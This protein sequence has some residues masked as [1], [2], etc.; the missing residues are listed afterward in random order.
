M[1]LSKAKFQYASGDVIVDTWIPPNSLT[2]E[3]H[4][5]V[6][7]DL[8]RLAPLYPPASKEWLGGRIASL[9]SHYFMATNSE[10]INTLIATDWLEALQYL[11]QSAVGGACKVWLENEKYKPKPSD[12]R[13]L[14]IK[15]CHPGF[16]F[17]ERLQILSKLPKENQNEESTGQVP[18]IPS[19]KPTDI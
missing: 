13:N 6:L 16:I 10:A 14:A 2:D 15:M 11:P 18:Q 17:Y 8:S 12:I 19:G 3:E 9:L 7:Q 4:S 5:K 1:I